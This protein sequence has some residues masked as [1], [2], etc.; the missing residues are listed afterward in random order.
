M[1]KRQVALA[2]REKVELRAAASSLLRLVALLIL[3]GLAALLVSGP[4][5]PH[6]RAAAEASHVAPRALLQPFGR[7]AAGAAHRDHLAL[8]G[9]MAEEPER[10]PGG[11]P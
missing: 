10:A 6:A 1:Y 8:V 4:H 7:P 5:L 9:V 3:P 2:R 11:T